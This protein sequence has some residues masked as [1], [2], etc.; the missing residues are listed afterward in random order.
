MCHSHVCLHVCGVVHYYA[1]NEC[2]AS[3]SQ[4]VYCYSDI[5]QHC[6]FVQICLH[7]CG[8]ILIQYSWWFIDTEI[9]MC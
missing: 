6:S 8:A 5:L 7:V 3:E 1:A 9:A 2:F 4:T